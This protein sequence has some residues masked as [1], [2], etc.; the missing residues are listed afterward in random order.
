MHFFC[1]LCMTGGLRCPPKKAMLNE[2]IEKIN[3]SN[4]FLWCKMT[5]FS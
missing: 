1:N 4:L 2:N 3:E 5:V